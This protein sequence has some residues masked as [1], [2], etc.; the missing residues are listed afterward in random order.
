MIKTIWFTVEEIYTVSIMN[1][2]FPA[3][4]EIIDDYMLRAGML[5]EYK[6]HQY[7]ISHSREC[8]ATSFIGKK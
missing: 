6:Y 7:R 1:W 5:H 2:T 3:S 8:S 4:Q